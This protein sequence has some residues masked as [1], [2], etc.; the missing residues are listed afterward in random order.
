M[1]QVILG[2]WRVPTALV[3]LR[4]QARL[5]RQLIRL[6]KEDEKVSRRIE[7]VRKKEEGYAPSHMSSLNVRD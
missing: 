2:P 6:C 5:E 3:L 7:L 1:G 4:Q